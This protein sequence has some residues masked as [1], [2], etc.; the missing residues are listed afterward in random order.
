MRVMTDPP[1]RTRSAWCR[2]RLPRRRRSP[3]NGHASWCR[4]SQPFPFVVCLERQLCDEQADAPL[5]FVGS[6]D[7]RGVGAFGVRTFGGGIG[8][9][10]V[11]VGRLTGKLR[12]D[13]SD[14]VA[15]C[16]DAVEA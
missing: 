9:A 14:L 2:S 12:A 8:H 13:L 3:C 15:Q 7:E 11:R 5:D 10:P 16:D 6:A 4:R 1:P